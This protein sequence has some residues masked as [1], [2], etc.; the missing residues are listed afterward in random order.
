MPHLAFTRPSLAPYHPLLAPVLLC[1]T[2]AWLC[3]ACTPTP[4]RFAC[5]QAGLL[6]PTCTPAPHRPAYASAL[7]RLLLVAF[8]LHVWWAK[9]DA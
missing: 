5:V 2:R 3:R 6:R 9:Q 8:S 7:L 1:P 4:L